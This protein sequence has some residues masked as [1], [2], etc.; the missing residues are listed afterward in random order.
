MS[1]VE[2]NKGEEYIVRSIQ[3]ET[4]V[5]RRLQMLGLTD[6][7]KVKIINRK[8]SGSMIVG[9]RGTRFAI[10]RRFAAG[11]LVGEGSK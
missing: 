2:G 10:G 1:L 11:I 4:A 3:L 7:S 8:R 6:G 5:K 9:I